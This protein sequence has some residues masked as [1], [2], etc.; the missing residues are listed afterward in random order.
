MKFFVLVAALAFSSAA[1]AQ[2][3]AGSE[4]TSVSQ[5]ESSSGAM[6]NNANNVNIISS[7]P[8]L[9]RHEST[10]ASTENINVSGTQHLK[11]NAP[12]FLAAAVS[13]SSDYCGG[14]ATGGAS[15]AGVTLGGGAPVFDPNCQ[16]LRRAEKLGMAAVSAYNMGMRSLA[17]KLEY[18]AVWQICVSDP[19]LQEA[20]YHQGVIT[21]N[22]MVNVSQAEPVLPA[23][24]D[25]PRSNAIQ[26]QQP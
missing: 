13:M 5:S 20:C 15:F 14:T 1:T 11:T 4:S 8:E 25:T 6:S 19:T 16:G 17:A 3:I 2:T 22:G 7:A 12:V 26:V 24:G 18:L 23:N 9:Q 10:S 21:D